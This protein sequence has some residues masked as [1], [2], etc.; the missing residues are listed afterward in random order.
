MLSELKQ[1]IGTLYEMND[2]IIDNYNISENM[3]DGYNRTDYI[4][5]KKNG[6]FAYTFW[7]DSGEYDEENMVGVYNIEFKILYYYDCDDDDVEFAK[8]SIIKISNFEQII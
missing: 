7:D 4:H 8:N 3:L 1:Y 2:F 5:D 6:S